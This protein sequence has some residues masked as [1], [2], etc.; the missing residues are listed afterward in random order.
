[1]FC[2]IIFILN[3]N[4]RI[5]QACCDVAFKYAHE[6]E[7]FGE[8]IGHFQVRFQMVYYVYMYIKVQIFR[9]L[10]EYQF[11]STLEVSLFLYKKKWSNTKFRLFM[12]SNIFKLHPYHMYI[13]WYS[14]LFRFKPCQG[15]TIVSFR[16]KLKILCI[17][18]VGSSMLVGSRTWFFF[19]KL[20]A[21]YTI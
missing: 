6:R 4:D 12:L 21:S 7:C 15:Q 19:Y 16:K 18:L 20:V 11:F 8:K 17:L 1:M 9:H 13:K 14:I 2:K 10:P 3:F 5:M